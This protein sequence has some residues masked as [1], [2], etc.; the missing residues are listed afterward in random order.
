MCG[1]A[2][3]V[4]VSF[5]HT[6]VSYSEE[7]RTT[8]GPTQTC[9]GKV[10]KSTHIKALQALVCGPPAAIAQSLMLGLRFKAVRGRITTVG[11]LE[12]QRT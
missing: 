4:K 12:I 11:Q 9:P 6:K 3:A 5:Y 8:F 1:E 7:T 10:L 2:V